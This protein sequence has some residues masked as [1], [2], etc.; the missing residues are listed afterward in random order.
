MRMRNQAPFEDD[1]TW[2]RRS[3]DMMRALAQW[4]LSQLP[5]PARVAKTAAKT[6]KPADAAAARDLATAPLRQGCKRSQHQV[7]DQQFSHASCRLKTVPKKQ[8]RRGFGTTRTH[9]GALP[10]QDIG[11]PIAIDIP[12]A[13]ESTTQAAI[14]CFPSEHHRRIF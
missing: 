14:G 10:H 8:I 5:K 2:R 6:A 11:K 4:K 7:N 3:S 13:T 1:A 12:G 9:E